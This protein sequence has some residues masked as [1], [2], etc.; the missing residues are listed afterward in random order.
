MGNYLIL[1]IGAICLLWLLYR[2][3][4]FIYPYVRPS[5]LKKYFLK[6]AYVVVTGSTD[7]IGKALAIELAKRGF[8]IILHGRNPHKLQAVEKEIKIDSPDLDV[9]CLL[10][11]GSKNSQMDIERIKHLPVNIL[12]N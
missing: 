6:N 10:H 4:S 12:V 1:S 8:N 5:N 2:L 11:D 9:I 3:I 7:G